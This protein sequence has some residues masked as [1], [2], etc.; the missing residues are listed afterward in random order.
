MTVQYSSLESNGLTELPEKVDGDFWAIRN[1]DIE[2]IEHW[3]KWYEE[4]DEELVFLAR[5]GV[6]GEIILMG[7]Q[8]EY[9]K[10][11]LKNK[12]VEYYEGTIVYPERPNTVLGQ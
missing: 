3:F 9:N 1:G 12:V 10:Y 7:E 11:V 4:F 8:G 6:T 5:A 2:P